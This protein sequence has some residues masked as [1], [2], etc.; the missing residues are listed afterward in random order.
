MW[1]RCRATLW[2]VTTA[3]RLVL[4]KLT[5]RRRTCARQERE[6]AQFC[7]STQLSVGV[8]TM[9]FTE[10]LH[11]QKDQRLCFGRRTA[12]CLEA[13]L[14]L[15]RGGRHVLHLELLAIA[16]GP[17]AFSPLRGVLQGGALG[18]DLQLGIVE[19]ACTCPHDSK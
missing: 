4:C 7:R 6:Q 16:R 12:P 11:F 3:G 17:Q 1:I 18:L 5:V 19:L 2:S 13:L 8:C 14:Q 9:S 15:L 10:E